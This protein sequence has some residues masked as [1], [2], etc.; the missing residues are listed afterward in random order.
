MSGSISRV[1]LV[2][3]AW[4]SRGVRV[5]GPDEDAFTLAVA[6]LERLRSGSSPGFTELARAELV[7]DFPPDVEWALAESLG[8]D[9]LQVNRRSPGTTSLFDAIATAAV[10][11]PEGPSR[12]VVVAVDMASSASGSSAPSA[13][14]ATAILLGTPPGAAVVGHASRHHPVERRPDASEWVRAAHRAAP[15]LP[16]DAT[17]VLGLIAEAPPPVLLAEWRKAFPSVHPS[18]RPWDD[19]GELPSCRGAIA[20][21]EHLRPAPAG[22][23]VLLAGVRRERTDFLAL[24]AGAPVTWVGDW[25]PTAPTLS[26]PPGATFALPAEALR[27]VSE[28]AY[29]PRPR[30][31]ENLAS[32]WRLL[33]ERCPACQRTTFPIRGRCHECGRTDGLERVELPREGLEV[34][35]VT[36]VSPGAQPTEF[37]PQ[38]AA[39]GAYSVVLVRLADGL[40]ATLQV[41]DAVGGS[42]RV[43]DRVAT[44][45]RRLYAMEGSWRYGLKAVLMPVP[46]QPSP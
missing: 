17:G 3:P 19:Q 11:R 4:G 39:T 20:L 21:E 10:N 13:A 22:A 5:E 26:V 24:R 30:Y 27:S 7:G 43:G 23:W 38:V 2:R 25:N 6:A 14:A 12:S 18:V 29:V 1:A 45:L 41:T 16:A 44:R 28:G 33:G 8:L 9:S 35:A 42:V 34:E 40:R 15:D 37:D 31:L 36:T 32:R 46:P